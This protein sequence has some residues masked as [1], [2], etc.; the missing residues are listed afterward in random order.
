MVFTA[1]EKALCVLQFAKCESIVMVQCRFH[2]QYHKDPP[3]DK[4]I[5]TWY[6]NFEQTG[7]LSAGKHW[8]RHTSQIDSP[9]LQWPPRSPDLTPWDFFLWGNV[10]LRLVNG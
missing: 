4:P 1:A 2:T 3:T 8:I 5:C 9:L 7:S 10:N 6:N